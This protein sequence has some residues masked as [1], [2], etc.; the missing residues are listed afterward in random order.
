[1]GFSMY[2]IESL[3]FCF[4][5]LLQRLSRRD[6]FASVLPG[7][8]VMPTE[9]HEHLV[10]HSLPS[11]E[12]SSKQQTEGTKALEVMHWLFQLLFL[13]FSSEL[14]YFYRCS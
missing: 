14:F 4:S 8:P 5:L 9:T 6:T 11:D 7:H 13:Y 2:H 10:D 1:M 3:F 12:H